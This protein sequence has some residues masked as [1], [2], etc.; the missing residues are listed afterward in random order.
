MMR[1]TLVLASLA[2]S[3][4]LLPVAIDAQSTVRPDAPAQNT[5]KEW[6]VPWG[7]RT[8]PRDPFA[9]ATGHVWFV[10]QEGNYVASLDP[11]SGQFRR[12]EIDP[13]TYPHDL[14]VE[15][16]QVWFTGNRNGR[17]V[18]LDPATGKLTTFVIPDST[19]GDPHTM[20]FDPKSGVA[21]FTAQNAGAIGRFDP[22]TGRFRIWKTGANTRPYGI[23]LDSQGRPWIDLFG[24]NR[25]ATVDP[26]SLELKTYELPDARAHP[27]R[28]AITSGDQLWW[29]DY[30]RGY[31][32]HLDPRTGKMEE[33]P[34]PA[35]A[36]SM[37]YGMTSDDR[38]VV[39]LAQGGYENVPA[40]LV[41]FDTHAR[42][43]V[44]RI[45]VGRPG[46]NTIRHMT[47]DRATRQ[48]WFG[49]DQG[50]IGRVIVPPAAP[51]Q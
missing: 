49:T 41:A 20:T 15:K 34:L 44:A 10:G 24:T 48:I 2:S 16:G 28:I 32:G 1:T 19:V 25:L 17:I 42:K 33:W 30:T 29:G 11:R 12:Y 51:V 31:L 38:D 9:D 46:P 3:A 18:R 22:A 26:R 40:S 47:F 27:R 37:P 50:T 45:P 23:V 43:F 4:V 5:V 21:W 6:E 14:V 39:W 35:G 7:A 13:G 36:A 8:R